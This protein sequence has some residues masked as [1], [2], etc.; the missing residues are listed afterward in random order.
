MWYLSWKVG[1]VTAVAGAAAPPMRLVAY[2]CIV[3]GAET[4]GNRLAGRDFATRFT[5]GTHGAGMDW[6]RHL[7]A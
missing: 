3:R 2:A 7:R 4:A 6:R 1:G 5:N